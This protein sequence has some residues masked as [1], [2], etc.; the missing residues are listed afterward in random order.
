[1]N[2]DCLGVLAKVPRKKYIKKLL[3][4]AVTVAHCHRAIPS[5]ATTPIAQQFPQDLELTA[6]EAHQLINSLIRLVKW[7]QQIQ[8]R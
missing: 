5:H 8:Y 1:M 3:E 7:C 6:E 2:W 4:Y